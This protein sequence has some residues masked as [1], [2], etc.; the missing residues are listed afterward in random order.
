MK[1]K[2]TIN[3]YRGREGAKIIIKSIRSHKILQCLNANLKILIA[4]YQLI[5]LCIFAPSFH[6][7]VLSFGFY[8][9]YD[10]D[11]IL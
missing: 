9:I 2:T 6:Y 4:F 11:L 3:L 7:Y 1:S 10:V 8:P 5:R